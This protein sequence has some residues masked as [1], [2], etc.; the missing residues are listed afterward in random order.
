MTTDLVDFFVN[1]FNGLDKNIIIF[2]ISL[3]PILELRGGLIAA[4]L[5]NLS[6]YSSFIICFFGNLLPIPFILLFIEKIL[7]W[8]KRFP[9]VRKTINKLE[10]KSMAKSEKIQRFKYM[11][12]FIFVAVP[13]PGTGA[14]TGALIAIL[15]GLDKK[16]SF[17]AIIFGVLVAG[18]IMSILSY[19]V[20][21]SLIR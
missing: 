18:I 12:L 20:L 14:W 17:I 3:M 11:G 19:G 9:K 2:I 15:L 13:L 7:N 1:L 4:S 8:F 5:L 6:F 21:G 16:K 10:M